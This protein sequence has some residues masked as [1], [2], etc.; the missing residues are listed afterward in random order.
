MKEL[1]KIHGP[2]VQDPRSVLFNI[3]VAYATGGGIPH[4][5]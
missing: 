3:D 2:N 5:R 1:S 4:G